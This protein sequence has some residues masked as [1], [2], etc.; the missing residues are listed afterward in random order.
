MII[1]SHT[2]LWWLEGSEEL[3]PTAAGHMNRASAGTSGE[4]TWILCPMSL[5]ELS[6]KQKNGKLETMVPVREWPG[7]LASFEWLTIPALGWERWTEMADLDW[8]H[9]DPVDRMIATMALSY[10]LPVLTRDQ[11]F[12]DSDSPVEAVW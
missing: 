7:T 8:A 9:R 10:R 1:D 4:G 6:W 2:L 12:H 3:S 5:W 11:K